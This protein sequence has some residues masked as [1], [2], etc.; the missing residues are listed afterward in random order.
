MQNFR[1]QDQRFVED[2]LLSKDWK[3]LSTFL[4]VC[5]LNFR[6]GFGTLPTISSPPYQNFKRGRDLVAKTVETSVL[7]ITLQI[8]QLTFKPAM[9]NWNFCINNVYK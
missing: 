8:S 7:D 1:G 3:K 6:A 2:W 4:K 9:L 5:F